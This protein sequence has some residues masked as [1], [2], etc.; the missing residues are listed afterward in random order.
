MQLYFMWAAAVRV[1][2]PC[3]SPDSASMPTAHNSALRSALLERCFSLMI[4]AR[5]CFDLHYAISVPPR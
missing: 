5:T 4:V 3:S 1:H 2:Q